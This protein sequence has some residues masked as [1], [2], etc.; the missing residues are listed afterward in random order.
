[1][2]VL[3]AVIAAFLQLDRIVIGQAY[4]M[5]EIPISYQSTYWSGGG[6]G[7]GFAQSTPPSPI[8]GPI[9]NAASLYASWSWGL[10]EE[11]LPEIRDFIAYRENMTMLGNFSINGVKAVKDIDCTGRAVSVL[12]VSSWPPVFT[13]DSNF[14]GPVTLRQEPR[15]A[16]WVDGIKYMNSTRTISTLVF[17]AINGTIE[18]G[19]WTDTTKSLK[20]ANFVGISAVQCAVDV[21]LIDTQMDVGVGGPENPAANISTLATI[22]GPT[23]SPGLNRSEYGTLGDVAAWLG[24][25]VTSFGDN[26]YGAQPL[27]QNEGN[28]TLPRTFTTITVDTSTQHWALADIENFISIGSGALASSITQEDNPY[29]ETI[30]S[31]LYQNKLVSSRGYLLFIPVG[32][33]VLAN[34]A[35]ALSLVCLYRKANIKVMRRATTSEMICSASNQSIWDGVREKHGIG[36]S[37]SDLESMRVKYQ[38]LREESHTKM[39]LVQL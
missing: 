1:M 39:G 29:K 23:P 15:M 13:V 12:D 14:S 2:I 25:V 20:T 7:F 30:T 32:A 19:T 27:F 10:S 24:V 36:E 9:T 22:T 37:C 5:R 38:T 35:L 21:T 6:I 17:A 18:G 8:P 33:I 31:S 4:T 34:F 11:P 3:V 26:I 16:V 28:G